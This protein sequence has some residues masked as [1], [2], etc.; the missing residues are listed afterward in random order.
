[1]SGQAKKSRRSWLP[2]WLWTQLRIRKLQRDVRKLDNHYRPLASDAKGDDKQAILSEW[3]FEELWLRSELA[4]HE[5]DKLRK[6]AHRWNVDTPSSESDPRTGRRY[7]PNALR[8][9]LRREIRDVRRE[10]VGWWIQVV[11]MPLIALVSSVTALVSLFYLL[12]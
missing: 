6:L 1:M 5:S 10:S 4:Q 7:I 12:Q 3:E 8:A 11:V 9:K 2:D